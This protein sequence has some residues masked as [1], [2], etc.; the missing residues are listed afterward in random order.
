MTM[1][2]LRAL[3]E[4]ELLKSCIINYL[5]STVGATLSTAAMSCGVGHGTVYQWR[6]A[7][8]EFKDNIDWARRIGHEVTHDFVESRLLTLVKEGNVA[9][10]IFYAKTRMRGRGYSEKHPLPL[11]DPNATQQKDEVITLAFNTGS[12]DLTDVPA[13]EAV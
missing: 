13:P 2:V 8:Q 4:V 10:T 9:A 6:L 12:D 1:G 11:I 3:D 7:D 5:M